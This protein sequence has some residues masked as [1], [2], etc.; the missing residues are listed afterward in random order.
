MDLLD[1]H[2][3]SLIGDEG[4]ERLVA[5]FYRRVPEDDI[6]G[7]MY[8]G[9]DLAAA[10][11]RLREFLV[12]RFGGP[13]RYIQRR[14]HPRLR[15]RHHPFAINQ[16]ARDR[17]LELMSAAIEEAKLPAEAEPLLRRFFADSATFLINQP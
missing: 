2:L 17:W 11:W 12:G 15:M 1:T 6:L 5:G 14:G 3:F 4:F 7:P 9:R 16:A 13:D 10:Q 8:H